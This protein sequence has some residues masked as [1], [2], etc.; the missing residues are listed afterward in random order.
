MTAISYILVELWQPKQFQ[1]QA[2]GFI[3]W[4]SGQK[5][6]FHHPDWYLTMVIDN[7][8]IINQ[9]YPVMVHWYPWH[10]N[11]AI[12]RSICAGLPLQ[13]NCLCR[14]TSGWWYVVNTQIRW[15]T[16]SRLKFAKMLICHRI[17]IKTIVIYCTMETMMQPGNNENL[18]V[19]WY[20]DHCAVTINFI[21]KH[22]SSDFSQ[23]NGHCTAGNHW[24]QLGLGW[25]AGAWTMRTA[26][27]VQNKRIRRPE[28]LLRTRVGGRQDGTQ[29]RLRYS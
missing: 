25:P 11:T 12:H 22:I 26:M 9:S 16:S 14:I 15:W 21:K 17:F 4:S 23:M 19:H 5:S 6:F 13:I 18:V 24:N 27:A 8:L 3:G 7:Q 2:R 29:Y 28:Q 20:K 10:E 1:G